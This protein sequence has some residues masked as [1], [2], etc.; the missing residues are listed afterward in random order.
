MASVKT[1]KA[2]TSADAADPVVE[3][4]SGV[5][6]APTVQPPV[7]VMVFRDKVYTSRVLIIPGGRQLKVAAGRV[8]AVV[9]DETALAY[10]RQHPELELVPE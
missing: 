9:N 5:Q 6:V 3:P 7:A 1:E 10:L 8:T 4:G 2:T